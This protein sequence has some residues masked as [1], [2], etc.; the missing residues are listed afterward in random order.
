MIDENNEN[1][2]VLATSDALR[3]AHE[4]GLDLIEVSPLAKPPVCRL[5]DFGKYL[6]QQEKQERQNRAKQKRI[7]VKGIRLSLKIG[8]H[9][10]EVRRGQAQKF[11]DAGHKVKVEMILRGRE[12]H[13]GDRAREKMRA[14]LA[15]FANTIRIEQPMSLQG[16]RLTTIITK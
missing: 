9:D 7:D 1:I 3:A 14:F 4:R 15:L 8:E 11:L 2:G 10:A 12:R 16:N 5:A 6:Y 13:Y